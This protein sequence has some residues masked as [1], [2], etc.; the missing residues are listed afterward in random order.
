[1]RLLIE[2]DILVRIDD[3]FILTIED[4]GFRVLVREISHASQ[5]FQK[6]LHFNN[7]QEE[8]DA[9]ND[10]IPGFEDIETG[11]DSEVGSK[12]AE[13]MIEASPVQ[14]VQ[15]HLGQVIRESQECSNSIQI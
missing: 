4:L 15:Y 2:T 13:V 9:S 5:F 14:E 3:E 10:G 11:C 12:Q 1:M 6:P 8:D 7:Q